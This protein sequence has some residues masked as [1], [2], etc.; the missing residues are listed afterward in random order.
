[1]FMNWLSIW[2]AITKCMRPVA[3]R[4]VDGIAGH[5]Y[6]RAREL[7]SV[8]QGDAVAQGIG[9]DIERE[10]FASELVGQHVAG[11]PGVG[12]DLEK[13]RHAAD[14]LAVRFDDG[15]AAHVLVQVVGDGA[16]GFTERGEVMKLHL[17]ALD[18]ERLGFGG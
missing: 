8:H 14:E 11:V 3:E 16:F 4:Q 1:M 5:A 13:R 9:G 10:A 17:R 18:G 6:G 7:P 12:A 2:Q 15:G